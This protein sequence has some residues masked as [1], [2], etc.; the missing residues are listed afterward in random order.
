M[1]NTE[2]NESMY[3]TNP[4]NGSKQ[5]YG[6][7]Q[8]DEEGMWTPVE[9]NIQMPADAKPGVPFM[10]P[11]GNIY[12]V[13]EGHPTPTM[14]TLAQNLNNAIPTPSSIIQM[15]P[16]VQPIALVPYASQNQP[17]LQYDPET[18]RPEQKTTTY[19]R[20]PYPGIC[21]CLAVFSIIGIALTLFFNAVGN[22]SA[23]SISA[24]GL[25]VVLSTLALLGVG[26]SSSAYYTDILSAKV[27]SIG[28]AFSQGIGTGLSVIA[29]PL[30]VVVALIT[31][32]Y[33]LI[34]YCV[35]L[36]SAK[37]PRN[38]SVASVILIVCGLVMYVSGYGIAKVV[39]AETDF[40]AYASGI[41]KIGAGL[42]SYV[43]TGI[44]LITLLL[45]AF[46]NK[47]AYVVDNGSAEVYI[48]Q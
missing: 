3:S 10:G 39:E 14:D 11:D 2:Y 31:F 12:C 40:V 17:L 35:K 16:I 23:D 4:Q 32:I 29:L 37:S 13:G 34:K 36:T 48:M 43:V 26:T 25:D 33:I 22:L 42:A 15:T 6:A 20:K 18:P 27:V 8:N 41:S 7:P 24:T 47:K 21:I 30:A 46:T 45:P 28:D 38:F 44:G 19:K 5:F 1:N 9:G